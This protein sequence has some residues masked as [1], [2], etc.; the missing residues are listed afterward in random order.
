MAS[1]T[2]TVSEKGQVTIPKDVRDALGI[3]P[4]DRVIFDVERGEK[5]VVRKARPS[6]L[7]DILA[8]WGPVGGS[9]VEHQRALRKGWE[10]RERRVRSSRH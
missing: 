4:G 10:D 9:A 6:R 8:T 7:A 1:G 5:A 3:H 2:G